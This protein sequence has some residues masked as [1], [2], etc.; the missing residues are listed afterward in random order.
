MLKSYTLTKNW[1]KGIKRATIKTMQP[2]LVSGIQPSGRL[3]IGNWLGALKNFVAL[4]ENGDHRCFFFVADLHSI[5]EPYDAGTKQA[6]VLDT[7]ASFVAAGIDPKRS[8]LF[9]QSQIPAHAELAW[10]LGAIAPFGELARMTQFK[11]K[12]ARREDSNVG[13]FTYPVLMTADIVLYDAA[14][15]PVGD[16]QVQHLELARTLARKFNARFGDTLTEPQP[17]LTRTPRVMSLSDPNRKMSKSEPA[18]C[19]FL[20]DAPEEI[21][22]KVMAAVTDSGT[23]IAYDAENKAGIANLLTIFANVTDT[24]VDELVTKYGTAKYSAFKKTLAKA[25]IKKFAPYRKKKTKLLAKPEALWKIAARGTKA[26]NAIAN[27]KL[28]EIKKKVGLL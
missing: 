17:L 21:T 20:D 18:G 19:L 23:G 27:A 28:A 26:A 25:I 2:N 3:H 15:V 11:D 24:T 7:L 1:N 6:Q 5:T 14:S 12:S 10:I 13:L 22:A 9:V 8:T 4:Q 16:D